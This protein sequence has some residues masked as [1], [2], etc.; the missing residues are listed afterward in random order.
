[1]NELLQEIKLLPAVIGSTIHING[2]KEI[3]SDLPKVFQAKSADIGRSMERLFKL[4]QARDISFIEVKFD[5]SVMLIRPV[6][7]ES[8]LI[9]ICESGVNFPLVNMTA[10]MLTSEL[11][12]AVDTARKGAGTKPEAQTPPVTKATPGADVNTI[13]HSGP[14]APTMKKMAN[15]LALSIGPISEMVLTDT[16]KAWANSGPAETGRIPELVEMLCR[17]IDDNGLE[18]EFLEQIS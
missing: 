13:I 2:K 5:E 3:F 12:N 16:V 14:L 17:E 7:Q 6:D 11:K 18:K 15:A 9:T 1:M 8:S 10:S 4:K